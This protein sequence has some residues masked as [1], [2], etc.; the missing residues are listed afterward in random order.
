MLKKKYIKKVV[1]S[2]LIAVT[3]YTKKKRNKIIYL[4]PINIILKL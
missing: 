2:F 3:I 4:T 1:K